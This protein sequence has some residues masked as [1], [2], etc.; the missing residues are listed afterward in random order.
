M[1]IDEELPV[2]PSKKAMNV[3]EGIPPIVCVFCGFITS[4]AFDLD[5]HLYEYH[6]YMLR[7]LPI[8]GPIDCR[9]EYAISLGT[10]WLT[11]PAGQ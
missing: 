1:T 10:P 8:R 2:P 4:I 7:K 6:R 3:I 9:I 11:K 5:I